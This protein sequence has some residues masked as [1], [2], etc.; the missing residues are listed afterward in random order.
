MDTFPGLVIYTSLLALSKNP[1]PWYDLNT[2]ENLLFRREDFSPPFDTPAWKHVSH[3]GDPQLDELAAR[4]KECCAPGWSARGGLDE[5]LAPRELPWWERTGKA[6]GGQTPANPA[7]PPPSTAGVPASSPSPQPD[8]Q[9]PPRREPG[10]PWW[11]AAQVDD[12]PGPKAPGPSAHPPARPDGGH[13]IGKALG[14][15]LAVGLII[16][17]IFGQLAAGLDVGL[18]VAIAVFIYLRMNRK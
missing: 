12:T 2:G 10:G 1:R 17:L 11:Q 13:K 7:S 14:A 16:G 8:P 5:L 15:G 3:I 6:A 9:R 4:L 18:L